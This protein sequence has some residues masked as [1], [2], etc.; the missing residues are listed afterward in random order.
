MKRQQRN[1]ES[2]DP[3]FQNQPYEIHRDDK[4]A[5]LAE[6]F[7]LPA[8]YLNQGIINRSEK[9]NDRADRKC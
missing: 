2:I 9:K 8:I 1:P 3:Y 4:G 6:V 5:L 7:L